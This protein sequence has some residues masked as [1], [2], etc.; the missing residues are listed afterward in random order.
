MN[1][2]N[3][4]TLLTYFFVLKIYHV[5]LSDKLVKGLTLG[6]GFQIEKMQLL[7]RID[8]A[9]GYLKFRINENVIKSLIL[10]GLTLNT[11]FRFI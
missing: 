3:Y 2:H 11:W 6:K 7:L 4:N 5:S 9:Q 1:P 10:P 8:L